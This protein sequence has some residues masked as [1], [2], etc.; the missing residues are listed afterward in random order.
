MLHGHVKLPVVH[1]A[2]YSMEWI[3]ILLPVFSEKKLKHV[4]V[5]NF[6]NCVFCWLYELG[7]EDQDILNVLQT[8]W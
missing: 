1:I 2:N 3:F 6:S 4:H 7:I 8:I 5:F